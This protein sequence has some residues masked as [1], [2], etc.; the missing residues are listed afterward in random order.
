M[1]CWPPWRWTPA[2]RMTDIAALPSIPCRFDSA[3]LGGAFLT[4]LG[5][6]SEAPFD[7]LNVCERSGDSPSSVRTNR[8]LLT[9]SLQLPAEPCWLPQRHTSIAVEAVHVASHDAVDAAYTS[10]AAT[11]LALKTADCL[12]IV[13]GSA[14]PNPA[15][16]AIHAGWRGLAG[17]IIQRS[18]ELSDINTATARAYIGPSIR[19]KHYEVDAAVREPI[20]ALDSRLE[21]CFAA[22]RPGHWHF[23]LQT[24]AT[25]LL[26]EYGVG[27]VVDT[28]L[29]SFADSRFFSY[30]RDGVTG[31]CAS[32]VWIR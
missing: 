31:R 10:Q 14:D 27:E 17:G 22:S 13:V 2:R 3:D 25:R 32:L 24:A 18:L 21:A 8:Q 28:G 12:P 20:L 30:R 15:I 26:L 5:G 11:V 23:S 19:A 6:C 7:E 29:C 16:L 4:R 1:T 9:K